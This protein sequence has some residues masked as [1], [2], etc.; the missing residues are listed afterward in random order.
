M[1]CEAVTE[2]LHVRLIGVP[3]L[4]AADGTLPTIPGPTIP[5]QKPWALLARLL[6]ADR[7]VTRRDLST[8]LFPE[9][10][11]PLGALRWSLASLRKVF[12]SPD[13][14]T[15]DPISRDLPDGVTVDVL[16]LR[17]GTLDVHSVGELLEGIDPACG[18]EFSTWLL[19]ARQQVAARIAAHLREG[20]I[21]AISRHDH[22]RAIELAELAAR[23]SPFDE[24]AHVLLV[25]ALAM[26]G[27]ADAALQHV[28]EVETLFRNEL[29]AD[30]SPALRS[31]ARASV[32]AEPPGVAPAVIANSLLASGRA[33]LAAGAID[34]G[35]DCLRRAGAQAESSGDDALLGQCLLELGS[36]LVHSVRGF[37]DEGSVLLDQ[38]VQLAQRSGDLPTA[39]AGLRERGYADTLAGRR[40][41]AQ[42]HLADALA[43]A[44]GDAAL[45]AGVHAVNGLNL[46]DWGRV[47]EGL[48]AYEHALDAAR[49]A[50]DRRW[51]GWALG[52]GGWAA[53]GADQRALATE[54]TDDCLEVVRELHWVS[55]EPWPM[56]VLN[57]LRLSGM[58]AGAT[59]PE[60]ERCY[61]MSCQLED[62]CWEAASGRVIALHHARSGDLD[63]A[64]RWITEARTRATRKT[65]TWI[66]MIGEVLLTEAE[67]RAAAGD[68]HGADAAAREL[69]ALAARANLDALLPRGVALVTELSTRR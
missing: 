57:E 22:E 30:P 10:A 58:P 33:A 17:D 49:S 66:A 39:V 19:V 6:L 59:P 24:G 48:L 31:A 55:F 61:A 67:L 53:L 56:A 26:A 38:A 42:L 37:D 25:K 29:G 44:D 69:I 54:W 21:T 50:S 9:A 64:L 34:A 68:V 36:A 4:E 12:G 41:Q 16:Q 8:E 43:L 52:L 23:R 45:T 7:P 13:V 46:A 20:T 14:F 18:P 11:D 1:V 5:G 2:M 15:G 35:L 32:A 60:L 3:S 51:E 62:P 28:M 40:P 65:D 27:H 47:P 63:T